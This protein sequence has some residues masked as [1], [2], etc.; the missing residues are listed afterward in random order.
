MSHFARIAL[1]L[2]AT[3]LLLLLP[4]SCGSQTTS[5]AE[6]VM[7]PDDEQEEIETPPE[8]VPEQVK[9]KAS[10][11]AAMLGPG[12]HVDCW[13]WDREDS[14]WECSVTGLPRTI[15]LDLEVDAGFSEIEF[16]FSFEE[17]RHAVP[18][19]AEMVEET[20]KVAESSLLEL[21]IRREELIAPEPDLAAMWQES[22]V[23]LEVQ[24][25]DGYDFEVDPFG[26]T[27]TRPDDDIDMAAP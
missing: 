24:C 17:V 12:A 25:P 5:D 13:F 20:C 9:T 6:R 26:S 10:E 3:F 2:S 1:V 16:V 19:L 27:T 15:E 8:E 14:V 18:Y 21:S 23:F 4:A 7:A 22:D 11:M